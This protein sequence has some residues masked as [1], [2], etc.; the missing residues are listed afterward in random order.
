[1]RP[2]IVSLLTIVLF[3]ASAQ[4][5]AQTQS[6]MNVDACSSLKKADA[7]LNRVYQQILGANTK[8]VN[9][10]KALRE[11]KRAWIAFRDAHVKS[12][13]PDPVRQR[14]PDVSLQRS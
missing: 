2:Q 1:M 11:S 4:I 9:F 5:F 12:I 13:F 7:E 8:D 3:A 14:L 6:Q 10:V